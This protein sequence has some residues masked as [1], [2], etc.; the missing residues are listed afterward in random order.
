MPEKLEIRISGRGGQGVILAGQI[1]GRAAV[2]DGKNVVQKGD[3]GA[4]ARGSAAES[5][6][7]I[8]DDKIGFP[9]VRRCD[10]LVAMSLEAVDK[11]VKDLK[12][13]GILLIDSSIV[14]KIPETKAKVFR[15]PATKIAK[16]AFGAAIYANMIMLG[17]FTKIAKVVK[18]ESMEKAIRE[19]VPEK[20]AEA[21]VNA[22]KRMVK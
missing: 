13:D 7:I 5:E 12:K 22:Y 15:I 16:E 2:H 18:E 6:V 11:H 9:A 4:E 19:S 3:Y 1:L 20:T 17:A 10:V 21:N 8:S 14:E